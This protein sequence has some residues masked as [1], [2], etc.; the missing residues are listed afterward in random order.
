MTLFCMPNF[1]VPS[2]TKLIASHPTK[3][4]YY[5]TVLMHPLSRNW[6][7]TGKHDRDIFRAGELRD[8]FPG[9]FVLL[10]QF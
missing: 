7:M 3:H 9:P 10:S 8:L 5:M 4:I 6:E 2:D 1:V